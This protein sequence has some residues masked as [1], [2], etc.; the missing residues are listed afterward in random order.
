MLAWLWKSPTIS[1]KFPV[2]LMSQASTFSGSPEASF[3]MWHHS[4]VWK[5]PQ[6]KTGWLSFW[7]LAMCKDHFNTGSAAT[8]TCWPFRAQICTS[9]MAIVPKSWQCYIAKMGAGV[10]GSSMEHIATSAAVSLCNISL[11][12]GFFTLF[13]KEG[14]WCLEALDAMRSDS[15]N[16]CSCYVLQDMG[17]V[18]SYDLCLD[19]I[20]IM[21]GVF[22]ERSR[23]WNSG[24][25]YLGLFISFLKIVPILLSSLCLVSVYLIN[26]NCF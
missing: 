12:K 7:S 8:M 6:Q 1:S 15:Q 3:V 16:C 17:H 21:Y 9:T 13:R 23:W 20:W 5:P 25:T 26:F 19:C 4:Y 2:T 11:F 18:C 10:A 24:I 22:W 14:C